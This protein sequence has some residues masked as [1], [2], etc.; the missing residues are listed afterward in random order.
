MTPVSS[1]T[2]SQEP[3]GS[4][5]LD[6]KRSACGPLSARILGIRRCSALLAKFILV[7]ENDGESRPSVPGSVD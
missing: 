7:R 2:P 3:R 4:S 1:L 5:A 6:D